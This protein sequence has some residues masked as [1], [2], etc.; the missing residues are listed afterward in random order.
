[1]SVYQTPELSTDERGVLELIEKQR[2]ELRDRVAEPRRW[3]GSLRRMSFA[4]A[5]QGS[6]SIEGYDASLDDVVAAV[7]GEPT[8]GTDAETKQALVGYRDAMTYV[9]QIADDETMSIDEGLLKGLQFMML[10]HDLNK[11]PG[12][13]RRGAIYVRREATGN[14]VYEGPDA[15]LVPGLIEELLKQL[16]EDDC[17]VIV[18]AA[19]AHLNL[20]MIHPFSDGNGRMARCLQTLVLARDKI[21]VPVFSSI[22]EFLG[23]NTQ[24]YYEVLGDVGQGSWNPGNDARPWVR[25]CLRA[26]F[27]QARTLL[28]RREEIE[29]VWRA[30]FDLVEKHGLVERCTAALMDAA[31]GFRVRRGSYQHAANLSWG[32]EVP[33]VTAS[34]DLKAMVQKGLLL[35]VGERRSRHYLASEELKAIREEIRRRRAPREERDPFRI[36]RNEEQLILPTG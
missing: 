32:E 21:V 26:H 2:D 28:Q 29:A 14:I 13:W 4:K 31:Y 24:T 30:C 15:E 36:V 23:R 12:R 8:V 16:R 1:M 34:R 19:M 17:H 5:V 33:D 11:N 3:N 18:K 9:L 10:K 6:N 22:E 7:D 35:P 27:L 20:V 25:F